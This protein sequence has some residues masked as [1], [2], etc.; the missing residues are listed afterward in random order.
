MVATVLCPN[1]C[2]HS[3][4]FYI[5]MIS[6]AQAQHPYVSMASLPLRPLLY[7]NG[8]RERAEQLAS[9]L[10]SILSERQLLSNR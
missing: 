6:N 7:L 10:A 9:W 1:Y 3:I 5:K 8:V 4:A 2:S